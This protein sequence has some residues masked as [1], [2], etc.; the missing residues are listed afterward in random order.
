MYRIPAFYHPTTL[1]LVDDDHDFLMGLALALGDYFRCHTFTEADEAEYFLHRMY[2]KQTL[3]DA[4]CLSI[5]DATWSDL[6][7]DIHIKSIY[8]R[9]FN[10]ERFNVNC[11]LIIDYDMPNRNGLE[12]ARALKAVLPIKIILL[13]GEADRETAINAFNAKEIDRFVSKGETNYRRKLIHYVQELQRDYFLEQSMAV[14]KTLGSQ[15][16]SVLEKPAFIELFE[17]ICE[18][19]R[20]V[21]YYL[22]DEACS[23]LLLDSLGQETWLILQSSL[24]AQSCYELADDEELAEDILSAL[25][26]KERLVFFRKGLEDIPPIDQWLFPEAKLLS[27]TNIYYALLHGKQGYT[28]CEEIHNYTDFLNK[29]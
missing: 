14:L 12:L 10:P 1:T 27:G 22:L 25:R 4:D 19:S 29:N 2:A 20:C 16:D 26:N 11:I 7:V 24:D 9:I 5:A 21:E 6:Q 13:T 17:S 15:K 3:G 18:Q 8:R 23:F 28:Q